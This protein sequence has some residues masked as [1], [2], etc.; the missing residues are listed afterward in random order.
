MSGCPP[1]AIITDQ[2]K[3]MQNAIG[4]VFPK[5]RHR[6]CLWHI[7]KKV[8]EKLRG[9][10]DYDSIKFHLLNVVYD[11][12]TIE[13]FEENWAK[14]ITA[15]QLEDN[16]WLAGLYD[17]RYRWVPAFVKDIFWA[18]MSTTHRSESMHAFFDGY[19]N[20]KTTLKQFVGNMIMLCLRRCN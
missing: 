20:S 5:V 9:Y 19:I 13:E 14:F 2:D 3:A 15:Y 4:I 16:D 10:K 6:W 12:M 7:L 11:S 1:N 8:P 18:G 17:E